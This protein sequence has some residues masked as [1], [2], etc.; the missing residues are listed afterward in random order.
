MQNPK[1]ILSML[2]VSSSILLA[3]GF[4]AFR[5]GVFD[6]KSAGKKQGENVK[7]YEPAKDTDNPYLMSGTKS[8]VNLIP[9]S[10]SEITP[11][12]PTE[13][14][15]VPAGPKLIMSGSKSLMRPSD[16]WTGPLFPKP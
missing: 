5:G 13:T 4:V 12:I 2:V 15:A 8:D 11:P 6:S 7:T 9:I 16:K 10:P 3:A 14:V 1:P